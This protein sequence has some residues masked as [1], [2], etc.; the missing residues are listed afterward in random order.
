M[1]VLG[2]R[3][4]FIWLIDT[5]THTY[6][7]IHYLYYFFG[8]CIF[9]PPSWCG[10]LRDAESRLLEDDDPPPNLN[11]W[12]NFSVW[13]VFSVRRSWTIVISSENIGV[14]SGC[15]GSKMLLRTTF[16][17]FCI[18][19]TN[20]GF[21]RPGRSGVIMTTAQKRPISA[22]DKKIDSCGLLIQTPSPLK[23]LRSL[24][25]CGI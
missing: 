10:W 1:S 8:S 21:R 25:A 5:D 22:S 20:S 2:K 12:R 18:L 7:Q 6:T 15:W 24:V 9:I 13:R 14:P 17:L 16:S 23:T 11:C 19:C 3:S 4:F